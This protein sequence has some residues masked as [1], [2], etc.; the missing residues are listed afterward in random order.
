MSAKSSLDELAERKRL[1]T[2][3]AEL[4]RAVLQIEAANARSKLVR[5]ADVREHLPG[6][7]WLMAGSAL[8]GFL[9]LRRWRFVLKW[10]P[11]VMPIWRLFR[12]MQS[13]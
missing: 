10:L 12:K 7:P 8:A 9:V 11:A 4:H 13:R 5:L 3:Q 6:G 1:L 2:Q